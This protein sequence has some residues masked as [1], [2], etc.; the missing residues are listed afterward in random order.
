MGLHTDPF[1]RIA[2]SSRFPRRR[3]NGWATCVAA[4]GGAAPGGPASDGTDLCSITAT[5][6][7]LCAPRLEDL[8][9]LIEHLTPADRVRLREELRVRYAASGESDGVVAAEPRRLR[10]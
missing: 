9:A 1:T 3:L 5:E 6:A 7:F 8:L 2:E 10:Q 4:Q